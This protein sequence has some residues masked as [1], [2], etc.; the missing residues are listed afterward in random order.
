[1]YTTVMRCV[2]GGE[3]STLGTLDNE[4]SENQRK[5][6][7]LPQLENGRLSPAELEERENLRARLAARR[8]LLACAKLDQDVIQEP[9][10]IIRQLNPGPNFQPVPVTVQVPENKEQEYQDTQPEKIV[11]YKE[12]SSTVQTDTKSSPLPTVRNRGRR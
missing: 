5:D 11:V 9:Q 12:D 4:A 3:T 2:P 1:M 7:P 10:D 8:R 6:L